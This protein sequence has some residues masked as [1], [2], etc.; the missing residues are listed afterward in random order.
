MA[1]MPNH[2]IAQSVRPEIQ[3]TNFNLGVLILY[4]FVIRVE[5]LE[6]NFENKTVQELFCVPHSSVRLL[7]EEVSVKQERIYTCER[8]ILMNQLHIHFCM[9]LDIRNRSKLKQKV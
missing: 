3:L 6:S 5:L 9:V 2:L 7:L 1:I 8:Y 4:I